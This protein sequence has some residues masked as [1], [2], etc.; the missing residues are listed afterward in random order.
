[1]TAGSGCQHCSDADAAVAWVRA[2]DLLR[3]IE[4]VAESHFGITVCRCASCAQDYV[5]IFCELIDWADGNDPQEWLV[6]P[7]TPTEAHRLASAGELGVGAALGGLSAR[8]YLRRWFGRQDE[9]PQ[10]CWA[11]GVVLLPPH[12]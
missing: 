5:W 10:A 1:M 8:R 7:V 2:R 6:V 4:I 3:E 9:V 12:D 11:S